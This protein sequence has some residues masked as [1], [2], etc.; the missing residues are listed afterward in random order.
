MVEITDRE[1]LEKWLEGRDR[2]D[3]VAIAARAALRV[4]PLTVLLLQKDPDKWARDL[5]SPSFRA[6]SISWVAALGPT[7]DI[8]MA[9][10]AAAA[11]Y[12]ASASDTAYASYAAAAAANAVDAATQAAAAAAANAAA[13]AYASANSYASAN[14]YASASWANV[15]LDAAVL[16]NGERTSDLIT[17]SLWSQAAPAPDRI[18]ESWQT[19][20]TL[21]LERTDEDWSVWTDWYDARLAGGGHINS[22]L[23]TARVLIP[24]EMWEQGPKVVNA[25]IRRL[26]AV[27]QPPQHDVAEVPPAGLPEALSDLPATPGVAVPSVYDGKTLDTAATPPPEREALGTLFGLLKREAGALSDRAALGNLPSEAVVNALGHYQSALPEHYDDLD[28]VLLGVEGELLLKKYEGDQDVIRAETPDKAALVEALLIAHDHLA[29]RLPVWLAF[30]AETE[31]QPEIT[32]EDEVVLEGEIVLVANE[33]ADAD[34][35]VNYRIPEALRKYLHLLREGSPTAAKA[36]LQG[37]K[38][39]VF[40]VLRFV[41]DY[42]SEVGLDALEDAKPG[43]KKALS[44]IFTTTVVGGVLALAA[45]FP[46]WG[47][48]MTRGM[49]FLKL[50]GLL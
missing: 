11:A 35:A 49:D 42:C 40:A 38:D 23:E 1:S 19:L 29:D 3:A 22:E 4:A 21:L 46:W 47:A 33:L 44:V 12:A 45:Q 32:P 34:A 39:I 16:E 8:G 17:R 2:A 13:N 48:A 10:D 6:S 7:H 24:G 26:M 5:I 28:A 15:S 50:I 25:E 30:K 18:L 41:R 9:S 27:H 20:G 43:L 14:A 31:A 36:A 37:V